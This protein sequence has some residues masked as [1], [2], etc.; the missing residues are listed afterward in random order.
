LAL[1][2]CIAKGDE[3]IVTLRNREDVPKIG[4]LLGSAGLSLLEMRLL[5]T[6]EEVF[7]KIRQKHDVEVTA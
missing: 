6:M 3:V 4:A 7:L 5:G 2:E 1:D